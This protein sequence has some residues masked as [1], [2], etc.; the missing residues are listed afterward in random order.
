M[1]KLSL[2]SMVLSALLLSAVGVARA[3]D[4]SVTGLFTGKAMLSLNGGA[5]RMVSAGQSID[6]VKLISA[7]SNAAVLEVDGKR[8]TLGL[9]QGISVGGGSS[10][11]SQTVTLTANSQ[12]HFVTLGSINGATTRFVVDT[13]ATYVSLSSAE[14][15]RLGLDYSRGER[16]AMSTANGVVPA[17]KVTLNTVRVGDISMNQVDAAVI[18][19]GSPPVTL[20]GMS[21]LNRVEMKR[22]GD[23]MTL[24]KRY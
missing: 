20:L 10:S 18:E 8:K 2:H 21:F 24:K 6:G 12:G 16:G 9:G 3:T 19:G 11:G 1:R 4:V 7:D 5:P 23:T 13:G 22:D 17:Y 14:A 15:R